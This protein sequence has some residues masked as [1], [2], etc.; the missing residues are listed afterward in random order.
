MKRLTVCAIL[1][2]TL[3]GCGFLQENSYVV[4]EP[5]DEDYDVALD[6]DVLIVNSYLSLKN[7]ILNM[8][9]D[10]TEEGIIR[11]EAY[12]GNLAEDLSQA[13]YEVS[14]VSPLGT[15]AVSS[16]TYD[17]SKIVSY[18]EVHINTTFKRTR[19]EI[20]S[21]VYVTDMDALR[22]KLQEAM[23]NYETRLVLRIGDYTSID[24]EEEVDTVYLEHPEFVFERPNTSLELYPESGTQRILEIRFTYVHSAE[25]LAECQKILQERLE[26]LSL[27]YGSSNSDLTNA[28]RFY[29]RLGRDAVVEQTQDGSRSLTNSAYGVLME[30]RATSY[31]FAQMYR[32]LLE[33]CDI[34]CQLI[35]GQ[36]D[37]AP[38]YWCLIE[39]DGAWFYVDPSTA[40][41]QENSEYFLM[42]NAEL[43]KNGYYMWNAS[44]Y[45]VVELPEHLKA[46]SDNDE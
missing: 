2:L 43:E 25:E 44:D 29:N 6:S 12:S 40:V 38:Q 34:P 31:G 8:V 36:K 9:E 22:A 1:L 14:K 13:V 11:A 5:H 28:K 45:P 16:M 39:L 26:Q 41:G 21:I 10:A 20:Q 35:A 30:E 27:I 7:A 15:Y 23:A 18:Y 19:E 42:G 33:S 4:V 46:P 17:Y 32:L 3:C 37:G 24:L